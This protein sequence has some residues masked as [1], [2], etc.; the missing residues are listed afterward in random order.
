[1]RNFHPAIRPQSLVGLVST[2]LL[3]ACSQIPLPPPSQVPPSKTRADAVL[4]PGNRITRDLVNLPPPQYRVPVGV[5]AFRDQTGQ[6]KPQPDSNLSNAVTQGAASLLVKSLLDS[7]WFIPLEREGLQN[8]L[9]ERRMSRAVQEASGDKN[10][11]FPQLMPAYYLLEGGITGYEQNV[12]TGGDG[13]NLLGIGADIKYQVDQVTVN[14][15]SVDVRSGQVVNSVLVTK[16]IFSQSL[17]ASTYKYVAYKTLLQAEGGFTTNE[18]AQL[19]VKEAI[20]AA[21][22]HL[23]LQGVRDK[24]WFLRNEADWQRPLVQGYLRDAESIVT[25]QLDAVVSDL[26]PLPAG[27]S[28]V[29]VMQAQQ[30]LIIRPPV[31]SDVGANGKPNGRSGG[32][33]LPEVPA[34]RGTDKAAPELLPSETGKD[35]VDM[36]QKPGVRPTAQTVKPKPL[37]INVSSR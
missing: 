26:L 5:Y 12:R 4:T 29:M 15:R 34:T 35:G 2:L 19:A 3:G 22:I 6:F 14:L 8:L 13:A 11:I 33:V 1:M 32:A 21:I 24:A 36:S 20:E 10:K 16:T 25:G 17:N 18:P 9:T 7:G 23:V 27:P 28:P 31:P 30:P 37:A